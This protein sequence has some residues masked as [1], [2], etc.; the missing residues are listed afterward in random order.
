MSQH[1]MNV[2]NGPGLTFRTDM[3]AALQALASQS[4]GATEPSPAFPCQVWADTGT[5]RLK[6]RDSA[7]TVWL[8]RGGLDS[9][10]SLPLEGGTMSGAIN[11]APTQTVA[12]ATTTD[13]GA[14]GSN[15][16]AISGTTTI[17]GLGSIAAGARRTVRFLSALLLTH[18]AT[19]LILP[20]GS[21]ITTA[22]NDTAEF[23]SLGPG[24]WLCLRY[25]RANG[26]SI[27]FSFD[28]SNILGTVSQAAGLPTGAI[29]ERGSNSNGEYVKYADG[30]MICWN[31]GI[32]TGATPTTAAGALF[33]TGL[34]TW[35]LPASFSTAHPI[36]AHV[37][38]SFSAWWCNAIPD[39]A[40]GSSV[41]F[42]TFAYS[43]GS[44]TSWTAFGLAIGR[45]Y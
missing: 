29:I 45:W 33:I 43:N 44:G 34:L 3:N 15:V 16:V 40:T 19:S 25:A 22:T 20:G 27:L 5:G 39:L 38:P 8:D 41:S 1:D 42:R 6:Q 24:N 26:K 30:T 9:F 2:A 13:I 4:S 32:A 35:T 21:S 37:A 12:A 7:N 17:T 11:E 31:S 18:N 36:V 14:A 23:L 10:G 28:R